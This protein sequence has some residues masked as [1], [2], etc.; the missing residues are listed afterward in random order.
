MDSDIA[1]K[2]IVALVTLAAVVFDWPRALAGLAVGYAGR[3]SAQPRIV[4][5][6]G[7][8]GVAAAGEVL[9]PIVGRTAGMSSG[10][11]VFG[12]I[13]AGAAAYGVHRVL[14]HIADL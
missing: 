7:V 8:V 12:L 10:S 11:F 6:L 4:T 14:F 13:A 2:I 9:Y 3:R 1:A 5:P